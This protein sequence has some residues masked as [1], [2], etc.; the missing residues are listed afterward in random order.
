MTSPSSAPPCSRGGSLR[1]IS[2]RAVRRTCWGVAAA[3]RSARRSRRDSI[4]AGGAG[5]D[6]VVP[7]PGGMAGVSGVRRR[8]GL[9]HGDV[10][11]RG[12]DESDLGL[13]P[14]PAWIEADARGGARRR[15][16]L[17]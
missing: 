13:S 11:Q 14:G 9:R 4:E 3:C 12:W 15:D 6:L 7:D 2:D 10:L 5:G 1:A 8:A 17:L 16:P